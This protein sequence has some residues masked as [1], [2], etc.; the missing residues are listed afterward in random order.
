MAY[1]EGYYCCLQCGYEV[2]DCQIACCCYWFQSGDWKPETEMTG[3]P[4]Q[5]IA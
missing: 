2:G 5:I 1:V 4:G 3:K